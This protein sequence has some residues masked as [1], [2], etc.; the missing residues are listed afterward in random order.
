MSQRKRFGE[1][2]IAA[3]KIDEDQLSSAL[4][5]QRRWG[6]RIGECLVRL[7][8]INEIELAQTLSSA[9]RLPLI[10]LSRID[11]NSITRE[12]LTMIPIQTARAHRVVPLAQ[13]EVQQ[14]KR[15]VVSTSDPS[16][17][18]VFDELQFKLGLPLLIMV[19]P[20]GEIEWFIRRFYLGE[21][22]ALSENYIS[23]AQSKP[24]EETPEFVLDNLSSIFEDAE[25]TGISK[26]HAKLPD[27]DKKR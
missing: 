18:R 9:L 12:L 8:F 26:P 14:K 13:R 17:Y 5:Y 15:L 16:N 22:E 24:N 23:L 6:K 11:P 20:D 27:K 10:N 1:I 25:F 7:G 19:S 3:G 4:G 21:L 2:L